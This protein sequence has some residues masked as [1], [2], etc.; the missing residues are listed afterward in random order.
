MK[1]LKKSSANQVDVHILVGRASGSEVNE[2]L[3]VHVF[4]FSKYH[5][6]VFQMPALMLCH[7]HPR[8]HHFLFI[9]TKRFRV[10]LWGNCQEKDSRLTLGHRKDDPSVSMLGRS[11]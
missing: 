10:V 3:N 4:S 6:A 9:S 1:V 5:G 7:D 2:S 11:G 8:S